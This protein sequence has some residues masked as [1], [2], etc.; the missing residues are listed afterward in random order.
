MHLAVLSYMAKKSIFKSLADTES[1]VA[2]DG[3]TFWLVTDNYCCNKLGRPRD[4]V[5]RPFKNDAT[6]QMALFW[7][8]PPSCHH[9]SLFS[10]TPSSL[11]HRP[12]SDKPFGK[13]NYEIHFGTFHNASHHKV[14]H[15]Q[16]AEE[17]KKQNIRVSTY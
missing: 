12:K 5:K 6:A 8:T 15:K 11:C 9:L 7:T 10:V 13:A 2:G 3:L 1:R 14:N 16:V 17:I 4:R